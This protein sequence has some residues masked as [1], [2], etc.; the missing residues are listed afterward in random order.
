[1]SK[2]FGSINRNQLIK[3]LRNTIET[4][5]LDIISTLLHVSLS[6]RCESTLSKVFE[7]NTGAPQGDCD[8]TPI[9]RLLLKPGPAPW[10]QALKNP[11]PEKHWKQ[12][13]ME[14]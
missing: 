5:E 2:A 8:W 11:D 12:L 7:T 3:D 10:T 14:K 6:V 13:D 1:M 4:D 9:Y